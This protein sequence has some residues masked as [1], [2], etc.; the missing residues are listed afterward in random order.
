MKI[1]FLRE[2]Y[3]IIFVTSL[4]PAQIVHSFTITDNNNALSQINSH[5]DGVKYQDPFQPSKLTIIA[6]GLIG[7]TANTE[8]NQFIEA[9]S[10]KWAHDLNAIA[11]SAAMKADF[12]AKKKDSN[13]IGGAEI[14]LRYF[15]SNFGFGLSGAAIVTSAAESNVASPTYLDTFNANMRF[16]YLPVMFDLL[17]RQSINSQFGFTLGAGISYGQANLDYSEND[18]IS[19]SETYKNEIDKSYVNYTIAF[20][21]IGEINYRM[22]KDWILTGGIEGMFGSVTN[23]KKDGQIFVN[24]KGEPISVS[25]NNQYFYIQASYI[26]F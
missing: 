15:I 14:G 20:R 4:I 21:V 7:Y 24:S 12:T 8:V 23:F 18:K 3:S 5:T 25:L 6:R 19:I 10:A 13:L 2:F 22:D 17:Y 16:S 1:K 9:K 11:Q 26:V